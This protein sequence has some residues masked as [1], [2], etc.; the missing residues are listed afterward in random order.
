MPCSELQ[1]EAEDQF[2]IRT[3][4]HLFFN[5]EHIPYN[6]HDVNLLFLFAT[7]KKGSQCFNKKP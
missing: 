3:L 7:L 6:A 1:T 5:F 2:R 4:V